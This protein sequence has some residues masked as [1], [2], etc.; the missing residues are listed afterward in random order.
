M[1]EKLLL[2]DVNALELKAK[3]ELRIQNQS[4]N[5]VGSIMAGR[6][7]RVLVVCG[8]LVPRSVR[9]RLC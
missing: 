2:I 3:D 5:L 4:K 1:K 8:L 6:Y 7:L 9:L